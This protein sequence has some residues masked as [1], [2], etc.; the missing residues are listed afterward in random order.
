MK[1]NT[2]P[3]LW[4]HGRGTELAWYHSCRCP[5]EAVTQSDRREV[6]GN[7]PLATKVSWLILPGVALA[8]FFVALSAIQ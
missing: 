8:V 3:R 4:S 1:S 5:G 6:S 2:Q 7:E